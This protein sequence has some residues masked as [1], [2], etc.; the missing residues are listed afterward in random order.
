MSEI[1]EPIVVTPEKELQTPEFFKKDIEKISGEVF[2]KKAASLPSGGT[3][4]YLHELYLFAN[5]PH[6]YKTIYFK[7]T[8]AVSYKS[9]GD[10]LADK[11]NIFENI[12]C[13]DFRPGNPSGT[14]NVIAMFSK[15]NVTSGP[16]GQ[17]AKAFY[18]GCFQKNDG[19][20]INGTIYDEI[21]SDIVTEL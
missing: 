14:E 16:S 15:L 18:L 6:A 10:V 19:T 17:S 8:T 9:F 2:D 20:T 11:N 13:F 12:F 5:S 21:V 7:T 4:L 1:V 3:K